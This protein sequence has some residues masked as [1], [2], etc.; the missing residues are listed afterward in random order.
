LAII[1]NV[2]RWVRP[3][4]FGLSV[5]IVVFTGMLIAACNTLLPDNPQVR[6]PDI[7]DQ[8][9][10]VD[11]LPRTSQ[12]SGPATLGRS[13]DPRAAVYNGSAQGADGN[14]AVTL[15]GAEHA[16]SGDGYDLNFE[17]APV[18]SVAKVILGDILGVGYI[19]DPRVQGTVTLTSG[20]PVSKGDVLYVLESALRV[21]NVALVRDTNGYR[22]SPAMRQLETAVSMWSQPMSVPKGALGSASYH[23]DLYQPRQSPSCS[24]TSRPSKVRCGSI[25]PEICL[26][27]KAADRSAKQPLKRSSISTPIGCAAKRSAFFL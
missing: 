20:R 2:S 1:R 18:T 24:R 27:F 26:L 6:S 15:E 9:Q 7:L 10:S 11:L 12:P 13:K 3:V 4:H 19:I 23:C 8:V 16:A 22:L 14:T 17:N 25:R 21:S 5:I